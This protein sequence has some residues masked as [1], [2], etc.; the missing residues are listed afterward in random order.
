MVS[1]IVLHPTACSTPR[2]HAWCAQRQPEVNT[3]LSCRLPISLLKSM[4]PADQLIKRALTKHSSNSGKGLLLVGGCLTMLC[5][6]HA[7][8]GSIM[9]RS[10]GSPVFLV[11]GREP[12]Y[13][14]KLSVFSCLL[15]YWKLFSRSGLLS[16]SIWFVFQHMIWHWICHCC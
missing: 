7:L 12:R 14:H 8:P 6:E 16:T 15:Y 4:F 9:S 10:P 3:C 13:P 1:V 2:V 11:P 5:G